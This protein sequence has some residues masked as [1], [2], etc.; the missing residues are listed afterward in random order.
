M[1]DTG[2]PV[3][4]G[5]SSS[6]AL[7]DYNSHVHSYVAGG[8]TLIN[9]TMVF[10]DNSNLDIDQDID[11][12]GIIPPGAVAVFAYIHQSAGEG[13]ANSIE[14][15]LVSG[16]PPPVVWLRG[17]LNPGD[18]VLSCDQVHGLVELIETAPDRK[19]HIH[20]GR[21]GQSSYVM[22]TILAYI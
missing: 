10:D 8:I 5:T 7:T 13:L 3:P 15:M 19:T 2:L 9:P 6:E 14:A 11:L 4:Q 22:I 1:P 20:V 18:L 12:S 17:Y 21:N 16:G